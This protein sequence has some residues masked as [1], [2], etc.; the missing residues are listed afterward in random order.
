MANLASEVR[1]QEEQNQVRK[2][3]ASALHALAAV[4]IAER[5]PIGE[6]TH[7]QSMAEW[8]KQHGSYTANNLDVVA[9]VQGYFDN[10]GV[11][12]FFTRAVHF[13]SVGD[14]TSKTSAKGT[15]NLLTPSAA[16]SPGATDSNTQP[17]NL[18]PGQTLVIS[19]DGG[20]DQTF[21]FAATSASRTA[22]ANGPYALTNG[23]TLQVAIDGG[24]T[25]TKTFN[26][27]EFVSIGAATV[28][29]VVASLNSFF[30]SN[31]MGCVAAPIASAFKITSNRRGTG[32]IVNVVGGSANAAF[33]FTTGA[34][35]GTGDASNID[36]VTAAEVVTKLSTLTGSV[37]SVVSGKVHI[38]SNTTGPSSSVQVKASST[39]TAVFP[40]NAVHAGGSG[41]PTNTL[42]VDGK[43]DGS[44]TANVT[45]Q[46]LAASST[47]TDHFNLYVLVNGVVKERF[48]NLTM[49]DADSNYAETVIND[50]NT[51]SV[52]IAVVDLDAFGPTASA[53]AQRP[54]DGTLGPLSGGND[55][56][57]GLTDSD[58]TG[59]ESANGTTGFRC[60]DADDIDTLIVPGRATSAVHNA[61]ITY[62]EITRAGLGFCV[63]DPPKTMTADQI[64]G[65]VESTA[66]LLGL[67][68]HAA[69]YWPNVLVTNPDKTLYG[70]SPTV[71]VAP[72][73]HIAGI[74]ARNDARKVG[75]SFEQPAGTQFG[76]PANVIGLEMT[77]VKKKNKRDLVFPKLIN[78]ISQEKGTPIFVD[79]ARTLNDQ[80]PWPS[81]GQRRGVIFVEKRLIPGL[82]FMRHRNIKPKLYAEGEKTVRL[83]LLE[84]C[85]NDAFKSTNPSEAFFIDFGPGLNPPSVQFAHQV[86]ARIGMATSEPAEYI[87][88]LITPDTR[89][90]DAELAALAGP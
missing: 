76:I 66:N 21:T 15:L 4:G 51:G 30:A 49:D 5:G 38:V 81:I 47:E 25:F 3:N 75:G 65:Y 68:D 87:I 26:T 82:A 39:A 43:T 69:I 73:G 80:S 63:L 62:I 89:A 46:V 9:A 23:W 2:I 35:A 12:L 59:G 37:A 36:A 31:G 86:Y 13:A 84:L 32:S 42:R 34:I 72:S 71:V 41:T 52:Y 29:E 55:G 8:Q 61:M 58:Y 22:G 64:V 20:G 11:D 1:A 17:F 85:R 78:P 57:A 10:G 77:E 45:V 27:G 67:S 44:Y 53:A 7:S 24:S 16:A 54:A 60:F 74:Y 50:A 6:R 48:F 70:N 90:L 19:I 56:L 33:T 79:G 83:F 14:P 18:E 40:D 88:L 28:A